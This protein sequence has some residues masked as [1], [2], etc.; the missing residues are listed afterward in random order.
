MIIEEYKK[1]EELVKEFNELKKSYEQ[2]DKADLF[3]YWSSLSRIGRSA[4]EISDRQYGVAMSRV[5]R[6]I[7]RLTTSTLATCF[8][9]VEGLLNLSAD[10]MF[11]RFAEYY[12]VENDLT[13][14]NR[15]EHVA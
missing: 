3:E 12:L 5:E 7:D 15:M 2:S 4:N 8:F 13:N 6:A 11:V 10:Y 1:L 14:L 9:A